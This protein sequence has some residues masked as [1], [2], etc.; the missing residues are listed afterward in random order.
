MNSEMGDVVAP[1]AALDIQARA[2]DYLV[3][4]RDRQSWTADDE[5]HLNVWLS[6]SMA[7]RIA[8]WRLESVWYRADRLN[9]L[10][11][12]S[13]SAT[14]PVSNRSRRG[15]ALFAVAA[16]FVV[17]LVAVTP[18]VRTLIAPSSEKTYA[19]AIGGRE[20]IRLADGSTIELNTNT[21]IR[22]AITPGTRKVELVRGEALFQVKHNASWPFV[23]LASGHRVVDLG[24]KFLAREDGA[25]LKV[26][27]IE[28]SARVE[29]KAAPD[30]KS[31][32]AIL[33]P[34]DEAVATTRGL[35][36]THKSD[37]ELNI[38]LGWQHGV[39]VFEHA[40]LAQVAREYNRYNVQKIVIGDTKAAARVITV[41]L[42]TNDVT[43][44]ARMAR[45]FLGLHVD[46]RQSGIVI[47]Q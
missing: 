11:S 10:R 26:V 34:G 19:T 37:R 24:T 42:P 35:S 14:K 31:N 8:Y 30:R 16:A 29:S 15:G 39:L 25:R 38:E 4:R 28:G 47:T 41:T 22:T 36:V 6:D 13:P 44:F 20:T 9:A 46:E 3:A 17:G 43:G 21:I 12:L 7:H 1:G 33:V 18:F 27:L 45:N 2:A 23:L 32:A 40:T 5:R